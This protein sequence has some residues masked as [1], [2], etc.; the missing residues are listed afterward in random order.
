MATCTLTGKKG[1]NGHKVSHSNIKTK[2]VLKPNVQKKRVF[3]IDTGRFVRIALST[4]AIRTLN[5]ISL[6]AM[7]AK[8]MKSFK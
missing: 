5:K 2:R 8:A 3:D 4:S 6:S 7:V 1:M